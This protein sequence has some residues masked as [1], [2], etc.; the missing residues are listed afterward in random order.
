MR[1]SLILPWGRFR[2]GMS[3]PF[4]HW[5]PTVVRVLEHKMY[6]VPFEGRKTATSV[7]PSPS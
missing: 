4:P 2:M 3:F 1:L 5:M 7:L 6:E